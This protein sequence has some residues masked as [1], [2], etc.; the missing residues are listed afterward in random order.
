MDFVTFALIIDDLVFPDGRT[1]MAVLGGGGP[2]TAFGMKLWA[3]RV[4]LVGGV[5]SDLP[6]HALTWLKTAG[7]DTTGLRPSDLWPTPRLAN[8]R[9]GWPP[10]PGLAYSRPG[11]WCA[12]GPPAGAA[13][14]RLPPGARLSPGRSS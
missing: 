6:P 1:M 7:I 4:G 10:H 13:S 12:V 8:F 14:A 9:G 2:Q 3:D 5:G 11:Y